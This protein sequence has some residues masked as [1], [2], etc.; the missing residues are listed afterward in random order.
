M[1]VFDALFWV[2]FYWDTDLPISFSFFWDF[3][4]TFHC[5]GCSGVLCSSKNLSSPCKRSGQNKQHKL[6]MR[7]HP[8]D[9][10]SC[11]DATM[12]SW[13]HP[14]WW[15]QDWGQTRQTLWSLRTR[16]AHYKCGSW[17]RPACPLQQN[18]LKAT[19]S[20]KP[21]LESA[22]RKDFCFNKDRTWYTVQK[23]LTIES[24]KNTILCSRCLNPTSAII[25]VWSMPGSADAESCE[26][27]TGELRQ[28]LTWRGL[29][30]IPRTLCTCAAMSSFWMMMSSLSKLPLFSR[31]VCGLHSLLP[32]LFKYSFVTDRRGVI[33]RD[34]QMKVSSSLTRTSI[35]WLTDTEKEE[36]WDMNTQWQR[37]TREAFNIPTVHLY[38]DLCLPLFF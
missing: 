33:V 22:G 28:W 5:Q 27:L 34:R 17:H 12:K 23:N 32:R 9:T 3:Q 14:V 38:F 6:C 4:C 29:G 21:E 30:E 37:G 20:K 2:S 18:S 24:D 1:S 16:T 25:Y 15:G 7:N 26:I 13:T 8:S 11:T 36:H 35:D 10:R 31:N 19:S